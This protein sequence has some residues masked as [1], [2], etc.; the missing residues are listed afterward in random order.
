MKI[1]HLKLQNY[2][3]FE[4]IELSLHPELTVIVGA[5]GAGKTALLDAITV[6]LGPFLS[7]FDDGRGEGFKPQDA[8]R[9][10]AK[11]NAFEMLSQYPVEVDVIAEWTYSPEEAEKTVY[12]PEPQQY[13]DVL[14]LTASELLAQ[15]T[16]TSYLG[17]QHLLRQ[18]SWGHQ[19][20]YWRRQ[21]LG[22]KNKT[23]VKDAKYLSAYA[24]WLQNTLRKGNHLLLPILGYYGTG[25]LWA[26]QKLTQ[27]SEH[28]LSDSR[29][30]GYR[31]CLN[32]SSSFKEFAYWFQQLHLA[33]VGNRDL[34]EQGIATPHDARLKDIRA[35]VVEAIN[36]CLADSEWENLHYSSATQE[37][38]MQKRDRGG[39]MPVSLLSD[40]IRNVLALAA[41]IAFRCCKLNGHLGVKATKQT[42]GIVMIDELDLHLNRSK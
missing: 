10:S 5:N 42:P 35:A 37:I 19:D 16:K 25:R 24:S 40:G 36:A 21:L 30:L 1:H 20:W 17:A 31:E 11:S 3:C 15:A 38:Q 33:I 18:Q 22:P 34:A 12:K 13:L 29:T 23:T 8:R 28:I 32:P 7:K 14:E 6:A 2:R 4:Q 9:I 26:L 41:D 27:S 39:V